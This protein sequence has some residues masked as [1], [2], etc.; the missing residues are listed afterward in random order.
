MIKGNLVNLFT[1]EIYPAEVEIQE[2]KIKCVRE[3][4]EE[5]DNY[6]LPGFIDAHIHIES[7]M[8]TPS[9]FAQMVVPHGT[10]AVVADPHE[11]ANVQG[12]AGV[13]YMIQD[14]ANVPLQ[15]FFTAPS[16]VPA[17]P[18][19][20]SGAV[21]GPEEI[22]NLL[23]RDD[24]VALGEMMNFPGVIADDPTVKRKIQ[25]ALKYKKPVD[26][27]APLLTGS[28]LCKYI[29]AGISTDHEC[30]TLEEALENFAGCAL[31]IS[32]DRWFLDR[33]ATHILAFEGDAHVEWFEGNFEA[34]EEDKVR[35]LGPES[36]EPHRV[37]YK[38][39]TR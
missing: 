2:G 18:F 7:S 29:S 15:F 14:A 38:K 36:I 23:Q 6:I 32:H 33:I 3:V 4:K 27:H 39:F 9:R 16:C 31:V 5:L 24:M 35:R 8:L 28:D 37:K 17:T 12:L 10:T 21:L 30:T 19:E 13:N 26:G 25:T 1:E 34:Y 22:D 11:I 20:T